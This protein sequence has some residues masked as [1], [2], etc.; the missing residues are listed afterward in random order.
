MDND[1]TEKEP[2]IK[3]R[4]CWISVFFL[5]GMLA[6]CS[7][8]A[9]ANDLKVEWKFKAGHECYYKS[10]QIDL[11]NVPDGTA[12]LYISMSDLSNGNYHGGGDVD[13]GGKGTVPE[14][15]ISGYRG[16]CP[17]STHEYEITVIA[18][19][20]TGKTL[21]KGVGIRECCDQFK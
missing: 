5:I 7:S 16:P 10:P 8:S 6:V 21:T 12:K 9:I 19:D 11:T 18:Q 15:A 3:E 2:K 13:Y 20:K 4:T 17:P 1:V 14:G